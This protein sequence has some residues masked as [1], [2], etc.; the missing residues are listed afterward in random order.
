MTYSPI[1][2]RLRECADDADA[3]T[4]RAAEL[5]RAVPEPASLSESARQRM[6][7]ALRASGRN[8][9]GFHLSAVQWAM[10]SVLLVSTA[11]ASSDR[12]W[13]PTWFHRKAAF[14]ERTT[15]AVVV[16]SSPAVQVPSKPTPPAREEPV[17]SNA[18]SATSARARISNA[19]RAIVSVEEPRSEPV[20]PRLLSDPQD[21]AIARALPKA[22]YDAETYSVLLEV[23]VSTEG[24][25][26]RVS[27]V[28]GQDA[29]VDRDVLEAVRRWKYRPGEVDGQPLA[30]CF[31]LVYRIQVQRD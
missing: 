20:R 9:R 30:M 13:L 21:D 16:D 31:P 27:I 12:N 2:K 22:V 4:A 8:G 11:A 29:S 28:R 18:S 25:V 23:C 3:T 7:R 6:L 24:D 5:L 15:D 26:T 14:V 1:D 17:S 19:K 10:L